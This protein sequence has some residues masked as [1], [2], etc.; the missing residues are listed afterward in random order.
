MTAIR[1]ILTLLLLTAAVLSGATVPAWAAFGDLV[2]VTPTIT[3]ISV[4]A[5]GTVTV[6][7]SCTTTTTVVKRTVYTNP[8]TGV[9]TQTA[10]SSTTTYAASST[11]VQGSTTSSA[12]GPGANETTTTTTTK[13]TALAV[14]VNW[15]ASGSRGV[16]GYL[17][18]AYL[19]NGTV[20]AM[21]QTGAGTLS[22]SQTVDADNLAYQ[23]RLSVTTL[24]SYGWTA[25]SP[26]TGYVTC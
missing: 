5:P 17:V 8:S 19:S 20:Y 1:R 6:D 26:L 15:T 12:A 3:T 11:N 24:T 23:P 25:Q 7:D 13:N 18:N 22:T 21:A 16:N 4:A 10:Y 2:S 14:T 9:Q